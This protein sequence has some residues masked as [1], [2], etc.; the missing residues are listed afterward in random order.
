MLYRSCPKMPCSPG[1][2]IWWH[3][4][5]VAV[6]ETWHVMVTTARRFGR[7]MHAIFAL[8][9]TFHSHTCMACSAV[10]LLGCCESHSMVLQLMK[11]I[12]VMVR[13][14]CGRVINTKTTRYCCK[15]AML[16]DL[17]G[18]SKRPHHRILQVSCYPSYRLPWTWMWPFRSVSAWEK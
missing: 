17:D 10:V 6:F 1:I 12:H 9:T 16:A 5:V 7:N 18:F 4:H 3:N 15:A 8:S 2:M 14:A 11:H 13:H